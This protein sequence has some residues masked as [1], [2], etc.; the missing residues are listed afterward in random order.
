[1]SVRVIFDCGGCNASAEGTQ[2][3]RKT[4][5][6]MSPMFGRWEPFNV[7]DAAPDGWVA[8]DP[9]TGCC[10]CP[11]CWR[12]IVDEIAEEVTA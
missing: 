12:G 10:Y 1:M 2:F 4:W 5:V 9:Y 7:E 11:D 8:S 3:L 6:Q